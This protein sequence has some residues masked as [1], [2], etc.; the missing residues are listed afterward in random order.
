MPLSIAKAG[1]KERETLEQ[2]RRQANERWIRDVVRA[3]QRKEDEL[4]LRK[5]GPRSEPS[6]QGANL[7]WQCCHCSNKA[8]T[9][10]LC[11]KCAHL[12]CRHCGDVD[13][14]RRQAA[15]AKSIPLKSHIERHSP[16]G[17]DVKAL[18]RKGQQL[19]LPLIV[20]G[21]E[22]ETIPDTGCSVNIVHPNVLFEVEKRGAFIDRS[23]QPKSISLQIANGESVEV[24]GPFYL[25]CAFLDRRSDVVQQK[26]YAATQLSS[27]ISFLLCMEFLERFQIFTLNSHRLIER[28]RC[29]QY[30][31]KLYNVGLT[32][33]EVFLT[34]NGIHVSV[35]ADTG[36]ELDL[37]DV[38]YASSKGFTTQRLQGND[39]RE[40]ELVDGSRVPLVAKTLMKVGVRRSDLMSQQAVSEKDQRHQAV[41]GR[42]SAPR[43]DVREVTIIPQQRTFYV[44]KGL[45]LVVVAG[46]ELLDSM[47]AF[48]RCVVSG[49]PVNCAAAMYPVPYRPPPPPRK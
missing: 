19:Q 4:G 1:A 28:T 42:H 20:E 32:C 45:K 8:L 46:Q 3:K 9:P 30:N 33:P 31:P 47:D 43:T 25:N 36:S 7:W 22:Y 35:R 15:T 5:D 11:P 26:F 23:Q 16:A 39:P 41:T 10:E 27:R 21:V 44:S 6:R 48:R 12:R 38:E 34:L 40:I 29:D 49:L 14:P 2:Q 13:D 37:I 18:I 17:I 24:M